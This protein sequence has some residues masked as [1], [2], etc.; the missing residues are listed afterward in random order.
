MALATYQALCIDATDASRL[1][2]FWASALRLDQTLREDGVVALT[3]R[4]AMWV[5]PVPEPRT[6]KQRMHMDV[7][8][9]S[10]EELVALG[11]TVLD[12]DSFPW[13]LMADPEGG[14]FCAFVREGDIT[15]PLYEV[16][17]DTADVP[18]HPQRIATWWA[19]VLGAQVM[20]EE[21]GAAAVEAIPGAPFECVVFVRV[22]E[23]KTTKNRL[24]IDVTTP[25]LGLLV[26]AGAVVLRPQG[27]DIGWTV[28]ADPDGN[29]FCAFVEA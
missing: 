20:D 28:L 12:G 10:V 6:V 29:E 7:N 3:G 26:D 9:G 21:D 18:G 27:D 13:T 1:G 24:H 25:D 17:V 22:P 5:D 14:E 11:A 23:P 4:H 15:E 19:D 2:A 16:V 8:T